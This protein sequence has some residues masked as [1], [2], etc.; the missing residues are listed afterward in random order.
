MQR[1]WIQRTL[2]WICFL[3]VCGP[4]I[5]I[6]KWGLQIRV[7]D[8]KSWRA[9]YK[10]LTKDP[11]PLIICSNHLTYIDSIILIYAFGHHLWYW[12][13]FRRLTWNTPGANYRSNKL[14]R[15]VFFFAKCLTIDRSGTRAHKMG[16]LSVVRD[17][18]KK[19]E[20]LTIFPEGR[21]SK[22]GF[23]DDS[24]LAY[25]VGKI[26]SELPSCR[27][28]C[29]HMR[30]PTQS[31]ASGFPKKGS[32]FHLSGELLSY[33][34]GELSAMKDPTTVVTLEIA[35]R[36]KKLEAAYFNQNRSL[37]GPSNEHRQTDRVDTPKTRL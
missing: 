30:S 24:K 35:K 19:G 9:R 12:L 10:E 32:L 31:Q 23:F 17:L 28:L 37:L 7:A 18:L 29:I 26:A 36:I 13:H 4:L 22:T 11:S 3:P 1:A 21:R 2:D 20:V 6:F 34:P 15:F 33:G 25:G 14:F 27:I 8:L 5:L 16:V